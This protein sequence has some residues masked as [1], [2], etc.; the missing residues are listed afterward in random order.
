MLFNPIDTGLN[1]LVERGPARGKSSIRVLVWEVLAWRRQMMTD[2]SRGRDAYNDEKST[3]GTFTRSSV[4]T[5]KV[6]SYSGPTSLACR[7]P[8]PVWGDE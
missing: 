6:P 7:L 3:P 2:L 1:H 4:S 5:P 8:R